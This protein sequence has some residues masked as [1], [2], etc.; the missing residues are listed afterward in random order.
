[1]F[2]GV[3]VAGSGDLVAVG[4]PGDPSA[5]YLVRVDGDGEDRS[6]RDRGAVH[7]YRRRE[8]LWVHEAYLKPGQPGDSLKFGW[9]VAVEGDLVAVGAPNAYFVPEGEAEPLI[10]ERVRGTGAVWLFERGPAGWADVVT[11]LPPLSSD[12]AAYGHAVAL[13]GGVLAVGDRTAGEVHLYEREPDGDRRW[14]LRATLSDPGSSRGSTAFGCSL[15][16][17]GDTLVVGDVDFVDRSNHGAEP[18]PGAAW[19]FHRG[20]EGRWEQEALLLGPEPWG[21][22][23]HGLSVDVRG[24]VVA[25]GAPKR[26]RG[27]SALLAGDTAV[28]LGDDTDV[29]SQHGAVCIYRRG[30]AGWEGVATLEAPEPHGQFFGSAVRVLPDGRVAVGAGLDAHGLDWS[31]TPKP[32]GHPPK[33]G[34]VHIVGPG[35]G[36]ESHVWRVEEVLVSDPPGGG[37]EFGNRIALLEDGTLL[38]GS[39]NESSSRRGVN[40]EVID[41]DA[42]ESGC[43]RVIEL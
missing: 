30:T 20:V 23:M 34:A 39:P 28:V 37:D 38:V 2:F 1:M 19:V 10:G 24:D 7:L 16:L 11:M 6:R 15:A 26:N 13:S 40:P 17:D 43:V 14:I 9:S 12:P 8:G 21:S 18:T 25:V 29:T 33:L 32:V 3:G 31:R 36:G 42:F 4:A 5:E 27:R 41:Q 22:S 35:P